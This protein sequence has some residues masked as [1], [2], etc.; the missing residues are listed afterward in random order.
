MLNV[1]SYNV[2]KTNFLV[3][4]ESESWYK[5]LIELVIGITGVF[6]TV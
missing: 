3:S 1:D 4:L 5:P 2:A 6:N